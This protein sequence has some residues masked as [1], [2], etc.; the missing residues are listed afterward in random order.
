MVG[1]SK[2]MAAG[3]AMSVAVCDNGMRT[4]RQLW[5]RD[6]AIGGQGSIGFQCYQQICER[7]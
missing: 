5:F 3:D 2:R 1:D 7:Q 6:F 4:G